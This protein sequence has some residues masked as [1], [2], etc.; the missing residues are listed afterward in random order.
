MAP[1]SGLEVCDALHRAEATR[2][3]PVIVY[4]GVTEAGVL[5]ALCGLGVR[6]FAIKPC[7]PTVIGREA[8]AL[9]E[10]RPVSE[11]VRVVTGYG[12]TLDELASDVQARAV[13]HNP[14]P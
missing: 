11:R 2:G 1:T 6:V 14:G 9:L 10:R 5:A 4:T 8:Y 3:I 7:L 12:E 13:H